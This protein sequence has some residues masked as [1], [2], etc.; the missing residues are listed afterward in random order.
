MNDKAKRQRI[1]K[2]L[3]YQ[4]AAR[5]GERV[6][7]A[8]CWAVSEAGERCPLGASGTYAF[9]VTLAERSERR[10]R[11]PL[12]LSH[13]MPDGPDRAIRTMLLSERMRGVDAYRAAV[14]AYTVFLNQILTARDTCPGCG[15][16]TGAPCRMVWNGNEALCV[17][18]GKVPGYSVCSA[19]LTPQHR[20]PRKVT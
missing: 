4:H 19:C 1:D 18:A 7:P 13:M 17:S 20:S 6:P 11:L 9:P 3:A 16:G 12:C 8:R 2:I 14:A 10:P 15:C 5:A